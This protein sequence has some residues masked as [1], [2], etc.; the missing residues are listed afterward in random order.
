V[1]A[2]ETVAERLAGCGVK[3]VMRFVVLV[4]A[5]APRGLWYEWS[6]GHGVAESELDVGRGS[7]VFSNRIYGDDR[8]RIHAPRG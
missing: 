1:E 8:R 6:R 7:D 4:A 3:V 2:R 5:A